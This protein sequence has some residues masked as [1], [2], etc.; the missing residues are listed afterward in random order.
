M[1]WWTSCFCSWIG[2][3]CFLFGDGRVR[4]GEKLKTRAKCFCWVPWDPIFDSTVPNL[5]VLVGT[6]VEMENLLA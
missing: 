6:G 1:S 3:L 4:I 5:F 2:G